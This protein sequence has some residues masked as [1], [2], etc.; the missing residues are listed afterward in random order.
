[1]ARNYLYPVG[2]IPLPEHCR[3]GLPCMHSLCT[4]ENSKLLTVYTRP[5]YTIQAPWNVYMILKHLRDFIVFILGA[6]YYHIFI[7]VYSCRAPR[8]SVGGMSP[9]KSCLAAA[10]EIGELKPFNK[11]AVSTLVTKAHAMENSKTQS[12]AVLGEPGSGKKT[13][14]GNLIYKACSVQLSR[15]QLTVPVWS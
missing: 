5:I 4:V 14:I 3:S 8:R 6:V 10:T 15:C 13:L 11:R 7:G 12:I 2:L 9:L 1:M